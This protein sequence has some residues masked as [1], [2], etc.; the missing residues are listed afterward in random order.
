MLKLL[1]GCLVV[2]CWSSWFDQLELLAV[3]VGFVEMF[4]EFEYWFLAVY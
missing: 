1:R 4:D 2:D 3:F